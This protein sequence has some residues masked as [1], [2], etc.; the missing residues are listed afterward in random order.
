MARVGRD[1]GVPDQQPAPHGPLGVGEGDGPVGWR[2]AGTHPP[3]RGRWAGRVLT[4]WERGAY[5]GGK[6][7][8][9]TINSW[10]KAS[11]HQTTHSLSV[12]ASIRIRARGRAPSTAA[13]LGLDADA[14]LDD[15]TPPG[16]HLDLAFPARRCQ[17]GP[18]LAAPFLRRRAQGALVGQSMPPRQAGG[19]PL[20]PSTLMVWPG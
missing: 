20:H 10:P 15:L 1:E 9:A 13:P 2:R 11:R 12:D 14:P 7:G 17:Y 5:M 6:F 18:W 4:L 19:Q 8:S 3:G 16:E